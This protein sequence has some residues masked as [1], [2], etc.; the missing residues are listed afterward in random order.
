MA[1][2]T[3]NAVDFVQVED[4]VTSLWLEACRLQFAALDGGDWADAARGWEALARACP[5]Q[6]LQDVAIYW[7]LA[8]EAAQKARP[9]PWWRR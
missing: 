9:R 5:Q 6:A 4:Q 2:T 3:T 1:F 8:G 7:T